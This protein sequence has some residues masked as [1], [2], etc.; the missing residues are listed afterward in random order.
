MDTVISAVVSDFISRFISFIV[1][2]YQAHQVATRKTSRLQR[3]LLRA[4]IVVEEADGRHI[5]N[6][7]MLLQLKQLRESM[8][9]GYYMLDTS[10]V[11]LYRRNGGVEVSQYKLQVQI[12]DNLEAMLD[13]MKEFLSVLMNCPPIVRQPYSTY[14]FMERCMFGRQVE[15][16]HIINFLL[17][18][19]SSLDVLPV[20]GPFYIGKSTL[21]EHA[22]REE[23]VQRSFSNML[24][25][26]SDDLK[27]IATNETDTDNNH[28][29]FLGPSCGRC[30]II[31][32]EL[33]HDSDVVAWGKLYRSLLCHGVESSKVILTSKM[34][35]VSSLGTVQALRLTRLREEEHWYFFRVLAFGSANPYDH[36]PDLAS[37]AKE[38]AMEIGGCGS[39]MTTRTVAMVLRGNLSVQFWSRALG[40]IRKSIQMHIHGFGEDPREI[41]SSKRYLSYFLSFRQDS[42]LMFCYNRYKTRSTMQGDMSS[43]KTPEDVLTSRPVKNGEMFDIAAQSQI[44]P[45]HTYVSCWIMEKNRRVHLGNKCLKRKRNMQKILT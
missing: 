35:C 28:R 16:E 31:V 10:E 12:M 36:H 8:Y 21:V 25:L 42:P 41:H 26:S 2:N 24:H 11:Q 40:S 34:D 38:I 22:C 9:R 33:V 43:K 44:P 4:S 7:G 6:H 5:T 39:L 14:L 23:I 18:P 13:D 30:M 32:V 17:S 1:E 3:M 19:C 29:K 15:K 20:I 37:I 45:Y 27:A